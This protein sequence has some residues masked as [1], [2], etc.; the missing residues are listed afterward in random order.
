MET[1]TTS[2]SEN[3][4]AAIIDLFLLF[5]NRTVYWQTEKNARERGMICNEVK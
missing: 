3:I 2:V 5:K 4:K 1:F